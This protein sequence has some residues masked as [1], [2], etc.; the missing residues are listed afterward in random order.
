MAYR[1]LLRRDTNE[2]WITNNPVLASGEPGFA[3]DTLIFKIGDGVTPWTELNYFS[4]PTG[5]TGDAGPTGIA[6]PTGA[7]GSIGLMGPTGAT[8]A[9]GN[10]GPTG[11]TGPLPTDYAGTGSN[12]F[13]GTQT[14]IGGT[15]GTIILQQYADL[16]F[17]DDASAEAGG[18]P[19]G[20]IYHNNGAVLIR[21]V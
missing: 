21:I 7:T 13:Y 4:G 12:S 14:I 20:G 8:G 11:P 5:A 6:G 1:I 19:L 3:T 16:N 18:V 2:N 15:V 17:T 10:Q 9:T